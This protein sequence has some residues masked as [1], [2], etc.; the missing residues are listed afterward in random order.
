M[1]LDVTWWGS[2]RM[3]CCRYIGLKEDGSWVYWK[4]RSS[5]QNNGEAV[6]L[7][8]KPCRGLIPPFYNTFLRLGLMAKVMAVKDMNYWD[9]ISCT[10]RGSVSD[11]Q[12]RPSSGCYYIIL[13]L[14]SNTGSKKNQVHGNGIRR[15]DFGVFCPIGSLFRSPL[16]LK[17]C[18]LLSLFGDCGR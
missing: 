9:L 6:D 4:M 15:S 14:V 17:V 11:L 18:S 8:T 1:V 2:G 13:L 10:V 5:K 7:L 3:R 12:Q 16:I